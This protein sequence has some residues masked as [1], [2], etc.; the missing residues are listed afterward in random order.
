MRRA[1]GQAIELG[2]FLLG[3]AELVDHLPGGN[4]GVR[5]RFHVGIHADGHARHLAQGAG[6]VFNRRQLARRFH[7]EHHDARGQAGVNFILRLAHSGKDDGGGCG[8]G[9]QGSG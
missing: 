9:A 4:V 7:V 2:G 6:A 3:H 1:R 5:V 8:S